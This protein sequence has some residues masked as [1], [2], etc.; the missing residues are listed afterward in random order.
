MISLSPLSPPWPAPTVPHPHLQSP[1]QEVTA[2]EAATVVCPPLLLPREDPC[3]LL[4]LIPL[5]I[6]Q[7]IVLRTTTWPPMEVFSA[8]IL[9]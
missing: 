6:H 5:H 8:P 1:V 2:E 4:D 7:L 3:Q 9:Q